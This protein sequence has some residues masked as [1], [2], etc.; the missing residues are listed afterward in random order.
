MSPQFHVQHDDCFETIAL[1]D[2][3]LSKWKRLAGFYSYNIKQMKHTPAENIFRKEVWN[4]LATTNED[5][6]VVTKVDADHEEITP[7]PEGESTDPSFQEEQND[8]QPDVDPTDDVPPL[9]P[10]RSGRNRVPTDEFLQS[11]AQQDFTFDHRV[12]QPAPYQLPPNAPPQTIAFSTYYDALHQDDYLIQDELQDPIYFQ[13]QLDKD[14]VYYNQ[15]MKAND[16]NEFQRAMK[17]E[18]DAHSDRKH[19]EVVPKNEVSDD[20]KVLDSVWVMR[21]KRNILTN[22]VYKHKARL[23]IH[24]GQQEF[25]INYYEMFSPVV[26]WFAVRILLIHAVIFKWNTR[27]I[28]FVLAY[29]QADVE[30]PLYMKMPSGITV[31]NFHR[32]THVLKLRKNLYGQKQAGR[33][34]FNHLSAKLLSITFTPSKVDPCIFYRG[35]CIFFFY[36]DD[37]IFMNPKQGDVDKAIAGIKAT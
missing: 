9:V 28:D 4:Q 25:A 2:R 19:W 11:V 31:K 7:P 35:P 30:T 16:K 14:A 5:S 18:L 23:N 17:K 26:N 27:Q 6:P 24:G 8:A 36:V 20:E 33:V 10:R 21:R 34:W 3:T 37:G 32:S 12:H 29:P 1:N 15:A 22:K 13:D